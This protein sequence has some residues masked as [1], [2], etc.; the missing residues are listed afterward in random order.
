[1]GAISF[2]GV[3]FTPPGAAAPVLDGLTLAIPEGALVGI[4][5]RSGGGKSTLLRLL[6][7]LDEPSSG[8]I[9]VD[10]VDVRRVMPDELPRVFGVPGQASRLF[11]RSLAD[12]LGLGLHP[13]P[14]EAEMREALRR[15][16]LA[17][18]AEPAGARNLGTEFHAVPPNFSGGEQRR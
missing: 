10:G 5:G 7:R 14:G 1:H 3:T 9:A 8:T 13:P 11:E 4:C 2:E 16:D 18:L 17:E 12:N 15:V 6:L